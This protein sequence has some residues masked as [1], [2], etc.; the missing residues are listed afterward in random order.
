MITFSI[1]VNNHQKPKQKLAVK[2]VLYLA[3]ES[4]VPILLTNRTSTNLTIMAIGLSTFRKL[5]NMNETNGGIEVNMF[6][7]E[8]GF[9][10]SLLV[11]F[12]MA[13]FSVAVGAFWSGQYRHGL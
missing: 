5:K 11:V 4:K 7:P 8:R 6:T 10:L 13:T 12:A 3:T 2:G 9:D 1:N